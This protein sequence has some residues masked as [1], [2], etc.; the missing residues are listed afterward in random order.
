MQLVS[1]AIRK[2]LPTQRDN[3]PRKHL[4]PKWEWFIEFFPSG[5]VGFG[6]VIRNVSSNGQKRGHMVSTYGIYI[7]DEN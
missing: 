2:G 6:H 7:Y 3:E 5:F 1:I 4:C